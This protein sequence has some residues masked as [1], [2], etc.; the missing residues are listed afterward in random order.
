MSKPSGSQSQA[1]LQALLQSGEPGAAR[2]GLGLGLSKPTPDHQPDL[3]VAGA[4]V[5]MVDM[6]KLTHGVLHTKFWVVDQTHF[7][8]GSAN[9]DWRSL[10]QVCL[11]PDHPPFQATPCSTGAQPPTV[12]PSIPEFSL[13]SSQWLPSHFLPG[14]SPNLA[15]YCPPPAHGS[16]GLP[17]V[18]SDSC[19]PLYR[20]FKALCI[21][22]SL[23]LHSLNASSKPSPALCW[24]MLGIRW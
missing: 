3:S 7:Y 18:P 1:D 12:P 23:T 5:R 20:A 10:T 22:L 4:Q 15:L 2:G 19:Q 11:H 17:L 24:V 16:L 8:I 13:S 21:H 9:M 6:Q 14:A